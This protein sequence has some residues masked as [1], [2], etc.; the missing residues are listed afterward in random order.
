MAAAYTRQRSGSTGQRRLRAWKRP[1]AQQ[2]RRDIRRDGSQRRD[3]DV[4]VP[5]TRVPELE[6]FVLR[7]TPRAVFG[8]GATV[9]PGGAVDD[10]RRARPRPGHRTWTT[11][12]R[13]PSS[14]CTEGGL[15]RR[16]AAVR[17]CF[18]E[19]GILL[20]RHARSRRTRPTP[21]A[22]VAR[23]AQRGSRD[24]RASARRRGSR[25]RRARPARVRALAHAARARRA[26][27]T[28]G[29]SSRARPTGKTARTTTTSWSRRRGSARRT[30]SRAHARGEIELILPTLRSRRRR[31][32]ASLPSPR[33]STRSTRAPRDAIRTASGDRRGIGRTGRAARATT[34]SRVV[35]LD[36][37]AARHHR[38]RR[39]AHSSRAEASR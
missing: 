29:S 31:S 25:H 2:S 1:I 39:A 9:F 30:R 19:A 23:R 34:P 11:P 8:P 12:R 18:E 20:A 22:R 16:I 15:L 10:D 32:A 7:R 13:A 26:G 3:R 5:A 17:E 14:A 21:E 36:D 27:T 28:R 37:P 38:A 33:C 35:A 6:V 4:V 24:V